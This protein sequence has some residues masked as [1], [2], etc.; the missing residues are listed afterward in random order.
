ML[1]KHL[2]DFC[3][4]SYVHESE[5]KGAS[6]ASFIKIKTAVSVELSMYFNISAFWI[7]LKKRVNSRVSEWMCSHWKP[8]KVF[9]L[10]I[11]KLKTFSVYLLVLS[12]CVASHSLQNHVQWSEV[13]FIKNKRH[14]MH[15]TLTPPSQKNARRTPDNHT[16]HRNNW[17]I[18]AKLI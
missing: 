1:P 12:S 2:L 8:E 13:H 10:L 3:Q 18:C 9:S 5:S 11:G 4:C 16:K 6:N 15:I 17:L 7:N 14:Y